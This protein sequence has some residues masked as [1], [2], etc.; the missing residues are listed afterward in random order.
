MRK[1]FLLGLIAGFAGIG[2]TTLAMGGLAP[3]Q[4][5]EITIVSWGGSFQA[6]QRKVYFEPFTKE[7]GITIREDEF[8]AGALPGLEAQVQAG[9]VQ[10]DVVDMGGHEIIAGCEKGLFEPLDISQ[11]G[12]ADRFFTGAVYECGIQTT[13]AGFTPVYNAESFPGEKPKTLQDFYDIAKFPGKRGL[14]KKAWQTMEAALIADGV[15]AKKVYDVLGTEAGLD[16]A[17]KKLD[18]IKPHVIWWGG[19]AQARQLLLDGE[20][21]MTFMPNARVIQAAEEYNKPLVIIWDGAAIT[22]DIWAIPKG[23]KNKE[24]AMKFL[25]FANRDDVQIEWPKVFRYGPPLKSAIA[26]TSEDIGRQMV[27]HPDNQKNSFVIDSVFW[28]DHLEDYEKRFN[29]W[30]SE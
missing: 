18:Q 2:L 9:N 29:A 27:T 4:A 6:A 19:L 17:L 10:W 14:R 8:S 7:T 1:S 26:A 25:Q 12:G 21:S 15:D 20:V 30:L 13:V 5:D 22:G 16:R 11:L 23:S 24:L 28:A 3:A